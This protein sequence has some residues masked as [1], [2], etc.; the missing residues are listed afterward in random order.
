MVRMAHPTC[1]WTLVRR[2]ALPEGASVL[3]KGGGAAIGYVG[4][5]YAGEAV[6]GV[7]LG[8]ASVP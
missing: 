1:S 6:Q 3:V 5:G 2:W 4:V 7:A 8:G